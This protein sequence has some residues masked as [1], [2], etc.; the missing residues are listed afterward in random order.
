MAKFWICCAYCFSHGTVVPVTTRAP[1][2]S[3]GIAEVSTAAQLIKQ[4]WDHL[5]LRT[6]PQLRLGGGSLV[7]VSGGEG[8]GKST[9]AAKVID[10]L[11]GAVVYL[12]SE[13]Q[14]GPALGEL[15]GRSG[16]KRHDFICAG[17]VGADQLYELVTSRRATALAIDSVQSSGIEAG[18]AR[19]LLATTGLQ[20]VV[21]I[22][23]LN[24]SG[25]VSGTRE[26]QHECDVHLRVEQGG[27]WQLLKSRYQPM[28]LSGSVFDPGVA[29][30]A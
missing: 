23:Q 25:D 27:D 12:S 26:F 19:H 17:Q 13:M 15:L 5:P 28:P 3:D 9:F 16:I 7:L 6:W 1:A 10:Q 30:V 2:R 4:S 24:K 20:L 18:D 14:L 11:P 22:A 8:A 21:A 29:D